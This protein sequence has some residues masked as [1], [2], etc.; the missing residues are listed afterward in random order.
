MK[1][2]ASPPV[3]WK[4]KRAMLVSLCAICFEDDILEKLPCCSHYFCSECTKKLFESHSTCPLCRENLY[5][6]E[7]LLE[8]MIKPMNM[9]Y[10]ILQQEYHRF[11]ELITKFDKPNTNNYYALKNLLNINYNRAKYCRGLNITNLEDLSE[12]MGITFESDIVYDHEAEFRKYVMTTKNIFISPYAEQKLLVKLEN[13]LIKHKKKITSIFLGIPNL[14]N[15]IELGYCNIYLGVVRKTIRPRLEAFQTYGI[16]KNS[17]FY[18]DGKYLYYTNNKLGITTKEIII[19]IG[20]FNNI[21]IFATKGRIWFYKKQL[22]YDY[23]S[24]GV[25]Q[26]FDEYFF[27]DFCINN[28]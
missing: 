28:L 26:S 12:L 16:D 24:D 5:S 22:Y 8:L 19:K 25:F 27:E 15:I 1:R 9:D 14:Q 4:S 17:S 6:L 3:I 13:S 7:Y 21:P 2:S 18:V 10:E 11:D 23:S 20:F